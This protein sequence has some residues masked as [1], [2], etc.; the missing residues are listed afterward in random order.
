ML[1]CLNGYDTL[2]VLL[3]LQSVATS[4][5]PNSAR[6]A[7]EYTNVQC[8]RIALP[9][10]PAPCGVLQ[11][12]LLLPRIGL[13]HARPPLLF[14]LFTLQLL[15]LLPSGHPNRP[16]VLTEDVGLDSCHPCQTDSFATE[17][18]ACNTYHLRS[19]DTESARASPSRRRSTC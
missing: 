7:R 18:A 6:N 5:P 15:F 19:R 8:P 9:L 16:P 10:S 14:N 4:A 3:S 12:G 2:F 17:H 13:D 11:D 1:D